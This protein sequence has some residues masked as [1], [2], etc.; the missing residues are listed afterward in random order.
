VVVSETSDKWDRGTVQAARDGEKK[1]VVSA[2]GS[3]PC[4]DRPMR[5]AVPPSLFA[6]SPRE[7]GR[8]LTTPSGYFERSK[9]T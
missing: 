7:V 2:G 4:G 5:E 6:C 3:G 8:T 9:G 1:R